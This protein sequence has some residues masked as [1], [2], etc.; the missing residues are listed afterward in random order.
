MRG[1]LPEE[2][3]VELF[4]EAVDDLQAGAEQSESGRQQAPGG[5]DIPPWRKIEEYRELRALN[6]LLEDDVYGYQPVR[7]LWEKD[8]H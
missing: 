3:D 4:P 7:K 6:H 5:S 8:G 2:C 1:Q